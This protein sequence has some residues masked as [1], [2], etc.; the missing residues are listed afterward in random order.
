MAQRRQR[1]KMTAE[2]IQAKLELWRPKT[3]LG[4]KVKAK[5][6]TDIATVIESG[7]QIMEA[8]IVDMLIPN[9]ETDFI[10]IGQAKGKF[11]GGK[12]TIFRKTQKKTREGNKLLYTVM[13]VV[14]N[15][16]GYVGIGIG[17]ARETVPAREKATRNAK[18]NLI[19]IARGCGSWQCTCGEPHSMPFKVEG[20]EA[21]VQ[22]KFMPA[23]KGTG[24]VLDAEIKKI[25]KLAGIKDVWCKTKG[26]SKQK[27]N[28]V[29]AAMKALRQGT[30]Q[31]VVACNLKYGSIH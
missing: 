18:L 17:K 8:E 11:G 20:R 30:R 6:I 19:Q 28:F 3:E 2:E 24:L 13:A 27:M 26:Q 10:L 23:P 29:S 1:P 9:L 5:E 4:R 25:F 21:S 12:R 14:G 22:V 15:K 16:D 31:R 7:H